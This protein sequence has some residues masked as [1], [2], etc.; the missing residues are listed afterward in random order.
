[1]KGFVA[2]MLAM[3]PELAAMD[4][5]VPVHLALSYDEELGCRGVR[6]L[7]S[8]LPELC[9]P[10]A[11]AIIGEPSNLTPVLAHKGKAAVRLVARGVPGH[12]SRPDL[13]ANA[14]HALV[15]ALAAAV[16]RV[17]FLSMVVF[18]NGGAGNSVARRVSR[19]QLGSKLNGL[20]ISLA[21]SRNASVFSGLANFFRA[22]S[23][24]PWHA[25][26]GPA[27][28]WSALARRVTPKGAQDIGRVPRD[29]AG[30]AAWRAPYG[31]ARSAPFRSTPP[32]P[33]AVKMQNSLSVVTYS[34]LFR[35]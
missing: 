27:L 7:L 34:A 24:P 6:H 19:Q 15:P 22:W 32:E 4:L 20:C 35:Q 26:H 21:T 5:R 10:P 18:P 3:A 1:M 8:A 25:W 30:C 17:S 11:G 29:G 16:A 33:C 12:S 14:I 9:A 28:F 13:G 31:Q 23:Q 2:A